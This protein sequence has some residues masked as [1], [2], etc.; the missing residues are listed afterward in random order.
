M[1]GSLTGGDLG[2]F[3]VVLPTLRTFANVLWK[4]KY[5]GVLNTIGVAPLERVSGVVV[6]SADNGTKVNVNYI[7]QLK[8]AGTTNPLTEPVDITA[9]YQQ[10]D[11]FLN[12][13][14]APRTFSTDVETFDLKVFGDA[15]AY[16]EEHEREFMQQ[17]SNFGS[18]LQ[19]VSSQMLDSFMGKVESDLINLI[20][21]TA[22]STAAGSRKYA[23]YNVG[24]SLTWED[25]DK[26]IRE[27]SG[28][29]AQSRRFV[30]II[31]PEASRLFASL[32]LPDITKAFALGQFS[33]L[34]SG[35]LI[36]IPSFFQ[37]T[38]I[39]TKTV[40]TV[41]YVRCILLGEAG[42]TYYYPGGGVITEITPPVQRTDGFD[43][44]VKWRGKFGIYIPRP[45]RGSA[46]VREFLIPTSML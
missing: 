19:F 8:S 31:P 26:A 18:L 29:L 1:S 11:Q 33:P 17:F 45:A 7:G 37:S 42:V 25:L 12:I 35:A 3:G 23:D 2:N 20:Y 10:G 15:F 46:L 34:A 39:G 14:L 32:A 28:I 21:S 44:W 22:G 43:Y 36:N 38:K 27:M 13:S 6:R 4:D 9:N 24:S 40:D 16:T 5:E 30:L 41:E